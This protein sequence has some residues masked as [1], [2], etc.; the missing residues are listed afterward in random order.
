MKFVDSNTSFSYE[1]LSLVQLLIL[2]SFLFLLNVT[3]GLIE[4]FCGGGLIVQ[5]ALGLVYGPPLANIIPESWLDSFLALGNLGLVLLIFQGSLNLNFLLCN[6]AHESFNQGGLSTRFDLLRENIALS[7]V[8]ALVGILTP[9]GLSLLSFIFV[10]DA[11]PLQGFTAGAALCSTSLGT[12]FAVLSSLHDHGPVDI[13]TTRIG[14]V[15]LAAAILDDVVGLIMASVVVETAQ[16]NVH[17]RGG[18][19]AWT[20]LRPLVAS[21]AMVLI[22]PIAV[23]WLMLPAFRWCLALLGS[24]VS[25]Y[26]PLLTVV[27]TLSA[28][29]AISNYTG[30]SMLFGAYVAG[31]MVGYLDSSA[32]YDSESPHETAFAT[33]IVPC[34]ERLF[35]PLFFATI[36]SAIP[37]RQL[38]KGSILWKGVLYSFL[39]C[40]GKMATGLCILAWPSSKTLIL[41]MPSQRSAAEEGGTQPVG[42]LLEVEGHMPSLGIHRTLANPSPVKTVRLPW[43]KQLPFYPAAFLSLAMVSRGEI[44]LL[45]AQLGRSVLGEEGFLVVMWAAVV[46]TFVGT[47][48]TGQVVRRRLEKCLGQGWGST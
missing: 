22:A 39:M 48:S 7:I 11:T 4:H 40:L 9:I 45:I 47:L 36:G 1:Q 46:C 8:V 10:F 15:L 44:S 33:H 17:V 24:R 12:T 34:N 31:C 26:L 35:V 6:H 5:I 37:F 30:T 28:M 20:I 42:I 16:Q 21:G 29:V 18:H 14:T 41:S 43:K 3:G 27:T 25:H 32:L 38:W 19:L 23:R 2:G 13:R